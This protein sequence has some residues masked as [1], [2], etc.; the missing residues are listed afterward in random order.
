MLVFAAADDGGVVEEVLGAAGATLEALEP[1]AAAGLVEVDHERLRFHHPLVR[2][3]IYQEA[4]SGSGKLRMLR[5]RARSRPIRPERSASSC[6]CGRPRRPACARPPRG[7]AP[8]AQPRRARSRDCGAR[9]AAELTVDEQER[10]GLFIQAAE[11]EWELGRVERSLEL[12]ARAKP[13]DLRLYERLRLSFLAEVFDERDWTGAS[14]A[15]AF[16][17]FAK[18]LTEA[19]RPRDAIRALE[20]SRSGAIGEIRTRETGSHRRSR[21]RASDLEN[22]AEL[23]FVLANADTCGKARVFFGR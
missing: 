18:E 3:A 5:L 22:N 7:G 15:A 16:A 13:L 21:R 11:A 20:P 6:S 1:A 4:G 10:G 23:I 14:P 9:A 12:L 17:V 19:G 2:S 8:G